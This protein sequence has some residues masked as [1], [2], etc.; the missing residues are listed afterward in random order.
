MQIIKFIWL[1]LS[2]IRQNGD[3]VLDT[4]EFCYFW[5]YVFH[6]VVWRCIASVVGNMTWASWQIYSWV[7]FTVE[8][9]SE[10]K[11]E[12]RSTFIKVWLNIKWHVFYG[13]Q[14]SFCSVVF[15]SCMYFLQCC[16][17]SVPVVVKFILWFA[18]CLQNCLVCARIL[19]VMSVRVNLSLIII[20]FQSKMC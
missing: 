4:S 14:C 8:S 10:K 17:V 13:P 19:A 16:N 12:K 7:Q 11:F 3:I 1:M 20:W 6:N 15:I 2:T 9:N 18:W 5:Y